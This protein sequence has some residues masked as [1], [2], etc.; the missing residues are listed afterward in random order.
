MDIDDLYRIAGTFTYNIPHFSLGAEYEFTTAY[1][2]N[3][4]TFNWKEGEYSS[5]HAVRDHRISAVIRYIF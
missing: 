3:E 4:G 5:S 1:Y 2:G